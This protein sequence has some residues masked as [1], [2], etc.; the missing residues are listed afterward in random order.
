MAGEGDL[1]PKVYN[2]HFRYRLWAL[3]VILQIGISTLVRQARYSNLLWTIQ[4][5]T[6]RQSTKQNNQPSQK[7]L[8]GQAANN[9]KFEVANNGKI[10][11]TA[12]ITAN[13]NSVFTSP[14]W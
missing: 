10:I 6:I 12:I 2:P 11:L 4:N 8:C 13:A 1:P 5:K 3:Y 7:Q 14:E 9:G